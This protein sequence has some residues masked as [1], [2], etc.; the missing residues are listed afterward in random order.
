MKKLILVGTLSVL[1]VGIFLGWSPIGRVGAQITE[2]FYSGDPDMRPGASNISKEAYLN[3]RDEWILMRRGVDP[4]KLVDPDQARSRA[5]NEMGSQMLQLDEDRRAGRLSPEVASNWFPVGPA[6]VPLGQTAGGREDP[7]TGRVISLAIHPT[8]PNIVFVGTAGGGLYRTMNG[9]AAQPIWI[10]MMD[11]IQQQSN[12][13]NALGTLSIGAIAFAPS[14]PD[15][16]YIGTGEQLTGY[17]GSGLYRIDNATQALPTLVGPINPTANYG[18]GAVPTFT[19][20]AISQ[21]LVHP[22]QPGTIFVATASGGGGLSTHNGSSSPPGVPPKGTLG[23]YRSTT[24]TAAAGSVSFTKITVNTAGNFATGNTDISDMVLDPSDATANTLITW[25]RSGGS[26]ADNCTPGNNCSGIYRSTNAMGAGTFTQ[27]LIALNASARGELTTNNVGGMVTVLAATG[28]SPGSAPNA[29]PNNCANDQ[30]GLIRRSIDGGITWVNTDATS[31]TQAGLLRAGDG[32]CGGQCFYDIGIALDPNNANIIQVG[33]SGNYGGCQTLTKR[34]TNGLTL[35]ENV[36]GLHAD[37]Q[38]FAT[39]PSSPSTVWTGNDGGVWRSTDSGATWSS[40]NGDPSV[41]TSPNGK[42][43][44]SQYVSIATHPTDREFMTGGTQD[45]GTHLKRSAANS[46]AW[47]QIAFGDGGYTVIDQNA[48]DTT[49]VRIY[50]TYYALAGAAAAISY[51]Y[52]TTTAD[53]EAKNW[54]TRDCVAGGAGNTRLDCNDAA[55]LFYPP[56]TVGPGTP[57]TVYYGTDRLYRSADGGDT[58][59]RVSQASIAGVGVAAS[60]ISIGSNDNF[61]LLGMRNGTVWATTT[62]S[63]TLVDVT[64]AGVP[65]TTVGKVMIDPNS[66]NAGAVTAYI[67][68]GGFGTV[69]T[70]MTH[71]WK[72]TNLGGGS[73]TWVPISTGLPDIPI[74]AIAIDRQSSTAPAP[75]PNI[76]IGTDI[77]VYQSTNGGTTWSVLNPG[78]SLPVI[79]IFDMSFQEQVGSGS[80]NRVLRIATHGRGIWEMTIAP[81]AA[82]VSVSGRVLSPDG[83]GLRNASVTLTDPNNVVRRVLTSSFGYYRFENVSTAGGQYTAAVGSRR[84]QYSPRVLNLSTNTVDVDFVGQ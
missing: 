65:A 40:M 55:V 13:F 29:N 52:V 38:V 8:N 5:I 83:R 62:G 47:N 51:E 69:A 63:S 27:R 18:D 56:M 16:V 25:V 57:N 68:Y 54:T 32:F 81:T 6:P 84:Y 77:G 12:G 71:M 48:T 49:N 20:R 1:A 41:T 35:T 19:Y 42:I 10:P 64:P 74:D 60:S 3:A 34:S 24:G 36:I 53:A 17:L 14:N 76:Y 82:N 7:V 75:A 39:A 72:T 37:V 23:I 50:H 33:G 73:A 78:N 67:A 66:S 2:Y 61:R 79:P 15:I 9:T 31:A 59:Q 43:S 45:N 44:A 28:E 46:G 21:I 11:T 58:M 26:V 70:P 4:E 22:T 80:P 30:N